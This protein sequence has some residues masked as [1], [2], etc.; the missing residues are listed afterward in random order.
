MDGDSE[1]ETDAALTPKLKVL[2]LSRHRQGKQEQVD[3]SFILAF[4]G[5]RMLIYRATE[6]SGSAGEGQ[7]GPAALTDLL[8]VG[9]RVI[10]LLPANIQDEI[11]RQEEQQAEDAAAI[12]AANPEQ[13]ADEEASSAEEAEDPA[14]YRGL[15]KDYLEEQRKAVA[16]FS[17]PLED[18]KQE[19]VLKTISAAEKLLDQELTM[20]D[21]KSKYREVED[22]MDSAR[23]DR[24]QGGD[25]KEEDEE[26]YAEVEKARNNGE[27]PDVAKELEEEGGEGSADGF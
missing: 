9:H 25:I 20:E 3:K 1:A 11:S 18:E 23:G 19:E 8:E 24:Y 22:V 27:D 6:G 7:F 12:A 4:S 15:L 17:P 16:K 5:D 10:Q 26:G 13:H 21:V 2:L 14:Y